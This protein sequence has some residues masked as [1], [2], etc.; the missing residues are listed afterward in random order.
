M[1]TLTPQGRGI[2]RTPA[3]IN[4]TDASQITNHANS[5]SPSSATL[6]NNA[7]GY[8]KM[9][10][11][12]QFAAVAGAATDYALFAYQVPTG[13]RLFVTG[14]DISTINT[15]AA[16]ATTAHIF[17]WS[18]GIKSTSVDLGAASSGIIRI[19]VGTQGL[20]S[21]AAIG[22]VAPDIRRTFD[23]ELVI[24]ADQYF[25]VIL[26]MPV[27]TNTGSQVIRGDVTIHGYWEAVPS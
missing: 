10:G 11:R 8:A 12:W 6:A 15:G 18:V 24:D 14:I 5:A 22:A 13:Y 7:A 25:H 20:L 26:Q 23:P 1:S 4:P 3:G 21:G 2:I 27:A 17:D 19:P 16:V 9:G